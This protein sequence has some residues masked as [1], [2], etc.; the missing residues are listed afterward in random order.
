MLGSQQHCQDA[1]NFLWDRNSSEGISGQT[2]K[3]GQEWEQGES[4]GG[5]PIPSPAEGV[6]NN[7]YLIDKGS[8]AELS[9]DIVGKTQLDAQF[10]LLVLQHGIK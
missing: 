3:K 10:D 9:Y 8:G 2:K 6:L 4:A 5:S 7:I 1:V